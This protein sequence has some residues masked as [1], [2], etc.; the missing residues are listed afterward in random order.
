MSFEVHCMHSL[1]RR[2]SFV[3][4]RQRIIPKLSRVV[5]LVA[6]A[7]TTTTAAAVQPV[8]SP[9]DDRVFDARRDSTTFYLIS[10]PRVLC[11]LALI[12]KH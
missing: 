8:C 10:A 5:V 7:A 12:F 3:M 6:I 9:D 11:A 1:L 2:Q 4:Y